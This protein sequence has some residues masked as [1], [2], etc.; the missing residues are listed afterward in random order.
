MVSARYF[1]CGE[2][3]ENDAT[4]GNCPMRI[5]AGFYTNNKVRAALLAQSLRHF[6]LAAAKASVIPIVCSW[7][8]TVGHHCRN[9]I[10]HF[11]LP[12]HGHLNIIL[13]IYQIIH[14][15]AEPWDYFAFCE[16]D[17]LYPETY[18]SELCD[19]LSSGQY[20]GVAS[21]NHVGLRPNGYAECWYRTQP[22]FAMVVRRDALLASLETKLWSAC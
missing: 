11:Q 5:L 4:D 13:Q 8:P 18:F 20:S 3:A 6:E 14:S 19:L 10:S 12:A 9:L 1:T 15:V 17:C 16:H 2:T 7:Q 22:L 21:E